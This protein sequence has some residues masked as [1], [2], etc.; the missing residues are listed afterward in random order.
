MVALCDS[1]A[2]KSV[3]AK[4]FSIESGHQLNRGHQLRNL[5]QVCLNIS[6]PTLTDLLLFARASRAGVIKDSSSRLS[7][8]KTAL[9]P[10][11]IS[12]STSAR[13][14]L[15][16]QSQSCKIAGRDLLDAFRFSLFNYSLSFIICELILLHGD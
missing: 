4:D 1:L 15:R 5:A 8:V 6:A 3:K 16:P 2:F 10:S 13:S 9:L 7:V 14:T 12:P 11:I